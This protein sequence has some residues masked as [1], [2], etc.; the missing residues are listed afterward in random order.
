[1]NCDIPVFNNSVTLN[2]LYYL[3]ILQ[4]TDKTPNKDYSFERFSIII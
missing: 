3:I 1:M 2:A 4:F